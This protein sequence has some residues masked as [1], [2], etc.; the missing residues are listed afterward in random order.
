MVFITIMQYFTTDKANW[1]KT[2]E[3]LLGSNCIYASVVHDYGQDYEILTKEMISGI[4][5]NSPKPATPLK[6]FFLPFSENVSHMPQIDEPRIILGIPACD[7]EGLKLLDEIYLDKD[8]PDAFYKE[9][10]AHTL[11]IAT[12]CF[13]VMPY[14]HCTSYGLNP[15][16]EDTADISVALIGNSI[17]LGIFTEK[18]EKFIEMNNSS[19]AYV[20]PEPAL[21]S[22]LALKHAETHKALEALNPRLPD[23]AETGRLVRNAPEKIWSRYAST[24]VSCG[25]CAVICP[26]C[27][28]FLLIDKE[29]FGK[30]KQ[31]DTCQYPG[32]ARVAGGE[33]PLHRLHVR[34]R[35]RYFCK[36]VWKPE[37]FHSKACTGCGRCIETCLGKINKNELFLELIN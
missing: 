18:G 15:W 1:D 14:C 2:L 12:D 26:T 8:F 11:L 13:S 21:T 28:C 6:N 27:S 35:N 10:R 20:C 19:G 34:F 16:I 5:Y 37:K 4:A 9:K 17:L 31:A 22:E 25:A 7:L 24:C 29:H 30:I 23:Y 36:Y 33:D 32:F 3:H